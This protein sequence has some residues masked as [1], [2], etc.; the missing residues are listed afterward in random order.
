MIVAVG[1]TLIECIDIVTL[2]EEANTGDLVTILF[3]Q[4]WK[5]GFEVTP[6]I[7][8][9]LRRVTALAVATAVRDGQGQTDLVRDFG[10]GNG[11]R[12]VFNH[13]L[14]HQLSADL[15]STAS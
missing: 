7:L 11:V 5:V 3:D 4:V 1:D 15:R 14:P 12:D 9:E 10:E 2:A 8:P 6:N 13:S